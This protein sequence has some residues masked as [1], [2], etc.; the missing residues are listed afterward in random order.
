MKKKRFKRL[1][2]FMSIVMMLSVLMPT[3]SQV[4]KAAGVEWD[5]A[6]PTGY[7][8]GYSGAIDILHVNGQVAFCV[9]PGK[10]VTTV[11]GYTKT[12]PKFSTAHWNE[13]IY[14]S[15]AGYNSSKNT[16]ADFAATQAYM[17]QVI[18]SWDGHS[19]DLDL[20]TNIPS[21]K[22]KV[23]AIKSE[24]TT[25]KNLASKNP[26]FAGKTYNVTVGTPITVTDSNS[27]LSRY[28][29]SS[30]STGI[31]VSKSGNKLTISA[32]EN[33]PEDAVV[34]LTYTPKNLIKSNNY[35][36]HPSSQDVANVGYLSPK[37]ITINLNVEKYGSLKI[38]KSSANTEMTSGNSCYS[39]A[40]A[41]Y[42][43]YNAD[44]DK[45]VATMTTDKNGEASVD[46]ILAGAYYVKEKTAPKGYSI[47]TEAHD[48]TIK[49]NQT[50]TLKLSDNPQNDP[51]GVLLQ[52]YDSETGESIPQGDGSLAG[53]EYTVKYY[54]AL[55]DS[56]EDLDGVKPTRTW[57]YK[58]NERGFIFLDDPD[59]YLV[60]NKSDELYYSSKGVPVIPLGTVTIQETKAPVGYFIN[61]EIYLDQITS[62][63]SGNE[64]VN[65]YNK[66]TDDTAQ[67][68][69]VKKMRLHIHKSGGDGDVPLGDA[70][71]SIK[72]KSE[73][74]E[75]LDA[76]Y[77][78]AEIWKGIDE[79]G[80]PQSG[81]SSARIAAAQVIAPDY[82]VVTTNDN[83]D[84]YTEALPFGTYVGKETDTPKNYKPTA[85]FEFTIN[86]D[87]SEVVEIENKMVHVYLND[88]PV[89]AY[90]KMVKKDADSGKT[91]VLNSATFKIKALEDIYDR[92]TNTLLYHAGDFVKQKVSGVWHEEF[93]TNS[94]GEIG[95]FAGENGSVTTPL[96]LEVGKYALT[97]ITVP[98]GYLVPEGD[99][100][101]T[102][103][104]V[105]DMPTEDAD[106]DKTIEVVMENAQP[107]GKITLEKTIEEIE[108]AD[109]ALIDKNADM[110]GIKF[111]LYA[112]EDI[113]DMADGEVK[114]DKGDLVGEY[115]L[116]K[117]GKLT[118]EGL[119]VGDYQLKELETLPGLVLDDTVYDINITKTD[120]TTKVISVAKEVVNKTTRTEIT[121]TDVTGDKELPGAKLTLTDKETG[122]EV[123]S[124]TSTEEAFVIAGLVEGKTYVLT[125]V[126]APDGYVLSASS[127]EFTVKDDGTTTTAT[128]KDKY[129]DIVKNDL[130]GN[131]LYGAKFEVTD[132]NNKVVDSWEVTKDDPQHK[133]RNLVEGKTYTLT[134]T[135]APDGYVMA[136]PVEIKVTEDKENQTYTVIDKQVE[137]SKTDVDGN[138]LAGMEYEVK[139]VATD[140]VVDEGVTN[141]ENPV[142]LNGLTVGHTYEL[143]ETKEP[144]NFVKKAEPLTFTVT[145]EME[146]QKVSLKDKFVE[147]TKSDV[148]GEPVVG[149]EFTVFDNDG[150]VVDSWTTSTDPHKVKNLVEG[151]TYTLEE[152]YA[153]EGYVKARPV[154]I[155]VTKEM[156]NQFYTVI[157][158]QVEFVKTDVDGNVLTGMEYVVTHNATKQIV[159]R[160]VTN[161][162]MRTFL[163]N[164]MVGE[165]YTLEEIAEPYGYA[166]KAEPITFTVTADN[167]IQTVSLDNKY[168]QVE[169]VD[170]NGNTVYGAE[171]S[172]FDKDGEV[173]DA[174]TVTEEDPHHKIVGLIEG[175]TYT[176]EEVYAPEGYVKALPVT[177]EVSKDS[178]N[179]VYTVVNKQVEFKKV[180]MDGNA[181][182]GME[183][184]V[185]NDR[186]KEIVDRGVTNA[187]MTTYLNNL[188]V[189]ET[190]TIYEKATP[191]GYATKA[192]PLTF[193]VTEDAETQ[194]VTLENKFV[195]VIKEDPAGNTVYGAEL[196]VLDKETGEA[197]DNWTVTEEDPAHKV[198]GLTEGKTYILTEQYAPDGYVMATDIEFTVNDTENQ[199]I[200]MVDKQVA[201]AKVDTDGKLIPGME[202]TVTS[203]KT[204]QIVDKGV[205]NADEVVYLNGLIAGGT[206]TLTETATP[207]G[208]ATA[209]PIT[210]TVGDD[211]RL[212][213][214]TLANKTV[215]F[216]KENNKG[217]VLSGGKFAL[218]DNEGNEMYQFTAKEEGVVLTGLSENESYS[219]KELEAPKGHDL[220]SKAVNFTVSTNIDDPTDKEDQVVTMVDKVTVVKTSDDTALGLMLIALMLS[221]GGLTA[222]GIRRRENH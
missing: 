184:V 6:T 199:T 165:T 79:K 187:K 16:K 141:D 169:K 180:D 47:D 149:A 190:Y 218:Y 118:I 130:D 152:V 57:V 83:G 200:T 20:D 88:K 30:K 38:K 160:G 140:S 55:Y 17:W 191:H 106:G 124:W 103:D 116:S 182:T 123:T 54:N 99:V 98:E 59:T 201:F 189:G 143:I 207:D 142:L 1:A 13:L 50:S 28:T 4:A 94:K 12:S 221:A 203:D 197:V 196:A 213:T 84:A 133:V 65:T 215:T 100:E 125:E 193:T 25:L 134:E 219:V 78:Y 150:E 29:V 81:V 82:D 188:A 154:T 32:A 181:L 208:F 211:D 192:E 138:L 220:N 2:W 77:T 39:L 122:K 7:Y 10:S 171:F 64:I 11:E 22:S 114:Y 146:I 90:A 67:S 156:E 58:T 117:D 33:A 35:F 89:K 158:K 101:F 60:E 194:V 174:W 43:V 155:E 139:D 52:K 34:K 18:R 175:E 159:D 44:T 9:E 126:V 166:K 108:D 135:Y 86:K 63:N 198:V 105:L 183:Y 179:Q 185:T 31:S 113:I 3:A 36:Y 157:D 95:T 92:Q 72:L 75:A 24:V 204:K 173:V 45:Q 62:D 109:F 71:F 27:L 69:K 74:Q 172:V 216:V 119:W 120:N 70:E 96:Q 153:P 102:I 205:T 23:S 26:S 87:E 131:V 46:K 202:Y 209:V 177:I 21:Y 127:V 61:D 164:L 73:V 104:N 51:A 148:N 161:A 8:N 40:G 107:K 97:E 5:E 176:L 178:V 217:D 110:S 151:Q 210:F 15:N 41:V 212:Q 129:V 128:M 121:K 56:V 137:F 136:A 76:G 48:V 91:V 111:G 85:D 145:D 66:P 167:E 168:V 186:T 132:E 222:L 37:T 68:E 14:I 80:R 19:I 42:G 206:Y 115:N 112:A 49:S 53:A 170:E 144:E 162:K 147:V 214:V 195:E 93:T 163:N